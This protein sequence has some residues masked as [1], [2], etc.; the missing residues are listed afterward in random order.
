MLKYCLTLSLLLLAGCQTAGNNDRQFYSYTDSQGNLVTVQA[1]KKSDPGSGE[2]NTSA[3]ARPSP[4]KSGN[5]GR[6]A[7]APVQLATDDLS[8]YRSSDDIDKEIREKESNRFVTYI[9]E[10]GQVVRQTV[11]MSAP[12]H[13][14]KSN[15]VDY[16]AFRARHDFQEGYRSIRADCCLNVLEKATPL[17]T[18][19]QQTVVFDD[20]SRALLSDKHYMAKAFLVADNVTAVVVRSYIQKNAYIAAQM[21]WLDAHGRPL[22][23][24]D[25]PFT[26]RYPETWMRYGYLQGT[27]PRNAGQ[28]YLLVFLQYNKIH[29]LTE[30]LEAGLHGDL[31]VRALAD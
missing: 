3:Q 7:T 8:Q 17:S 13:A 30:G 29:A 2:A 28:K 25:Q 1:S 12:E 9:D 26:R 23:L 4:G 22:M 20:K 19:K 14:K 27:I 18:T 10:K 11:D 21:L 24:V 6:P 16:R 5:N 31:V 15:D